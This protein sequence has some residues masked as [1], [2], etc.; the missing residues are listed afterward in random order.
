[1][2]A[3][4]FGEEE[5]RWTTVDP[6][7][8]WEQSYGYVMCEPVNQSDRSGMCAI[9]G[10][11]SFTN[12]NCI[13]KCNRAGP[14]SCKRD[15]CYI[16]TEYQLYI[17]IT[18]NSCTNCAVYQFLRYN[19]GGWHRD[20]GTP[21]TWPNIKCPGSG[22]IFQDF[23]GYGFRGSPCLSINYSADFITCVCCKESSKCF[24]WSYAT[25]IRDC[26]SGTCTFKNI[27]LLSPV[28]ASNKWCQDAK[29]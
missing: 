29:K 6:M 14:L 25:H 5:G 3:R 17:N 4:H 10:L 15:E 22:C 18:L 27:A 11:G 9:K 28:S 12:L 16:N 26:S 23:P 8:P 19:G 1:M 2:I 21:P 24:T 20:I 7:W 13:K